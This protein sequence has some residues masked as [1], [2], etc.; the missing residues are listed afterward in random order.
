MYRS[1][2]FLFGAMFVFVTFADTTIHS[3]NKKRKRYVENNNTIE[4]IVC[5]CCSIYCTKIMYTGGMRKVVAKPATAPRS[6]LGR[7]VAWG[8]AGILVVMAVA[9]LFAFEAFIPL[10]DNYALAGGYGT[11]TLVASIVVLT[12]IFAVPFLLRMHVSDAMRWFSL[13]CSVIAPLI[14]LKLA[15]DSALRGESLINGG[16]LGEK[17]AVATGAQLVVSAVLVV[18]ALYV[19]RSLWPLAKK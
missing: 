8:Y 1:T 14:W 7:N 9:Q 4:K 12:E 3:E 16:M 10:I 11:A 17:V 13:V 6:T 15:L 19:V 18:V 2:I 5:I